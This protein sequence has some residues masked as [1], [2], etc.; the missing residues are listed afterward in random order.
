MVRTAPFQG[1]NVGSIP[2]AVICFV[3][4]YEG[5]IGTNEFSYGE[6]K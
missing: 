4:S 1:A 5:R 3:G 6:L 2:I